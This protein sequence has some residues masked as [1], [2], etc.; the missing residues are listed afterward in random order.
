MSR[1]RVVVACLAAVGMSVLAGVGPLASVLPAGAADEHRATVVVDTGN[2]T[3]QRTVTF[4]EDSI[5]GIA[6]LQRAGANP[7]VYNF[8]GRGGAVCRLFGVGRDAGPGCLGGADGDSRYWAYFRAPAG[9][10]KFAYSSVGAGAT[11]VH[12]GDVEGWKFGLGSAPAFPVVTPPP[13]SPPPTTPPPTQPKPPVDPGSKPVTNPAA[14]AQS[15]GA[16]GVIGA[17]AT[18]GGTLPVTGGAAGAKATNDAAKR[19]SATGARGTTEAARRAASKDDPTLQATAR[20]AS[21]ADSSS[22]SGGP[23]GL[24]AFAALALVIVGAVL[25]VRRSRHGSNP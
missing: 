22:G 15:T 7:V 18:N 24:L 4:T 2:G 12:D 25:L 17:A 19:T 11:A 21:V 14:T 5:S 9:S 16:P 1:T 20:R 8:N 13:T 6:A 3:F 10:S 23:L